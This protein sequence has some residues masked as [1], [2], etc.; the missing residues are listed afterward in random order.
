ML[1]DWEYAQLADPV[2]D[3]ACP[4]VYYPGLR[5]RGGELLGMAGITD[6]KASCGCGCNARLFDSLNQLWEY[7]ETSRLA[8]CDA[9]LRRESFA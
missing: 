2:C 5:L 6:A 8:E 1:V 4:S 3:L 9:Q 7:A